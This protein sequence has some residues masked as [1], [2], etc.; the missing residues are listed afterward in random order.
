MNKLSA[1]FFAD[2]VA[3]EKASNEKRVHVY[4]ATYQCPRLVDALRHCFR[5]GTGNAIEIGCMAG[6]T[7]KLLAQV[8]AEY[9]RT[10]VCVDPWKN[11]PRHDWIDF[12]TPFVTFME[13]I[14]PYADRVQVIRLPSQNPLAIQLI[15]EHEY[16]F[17]FVDGDHAMESVRVDLQTVLPVTKY[18]VASDDHRYETQVQAA[19]AQIVKEFPDW[20]F[21]PFAD[22][23]EAWFIK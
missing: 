19:H 10:L 1:K 16:A 18:A 15:Q 2:Y 5:R 23:R 13:V 21:K 17:A 11:M 8:C 3:L 6:A 14:A 20:K 9:D 4:G 7:S 12:E 22:F